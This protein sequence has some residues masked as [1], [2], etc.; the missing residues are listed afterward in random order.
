MNDTSTFKGGYIEHKKKNLGKIILLI[1]LLIIAVVVGLMVGFSYL[2]TD[3]LAVYEKAINET[4]ELLNEAIDKVENNTFQL[5]YLNDPFVFN[6]DFKIVSNLEELSSLTDVNFD[7][8][9]GLDVA[10]ELMNFEL[11][12]TANNNHVI[13]ALFYYANNNMYFQSMDLYEQVIDYGSQDWEEIFSTNSFTV[14]SIELADIRQ[15]I[16]EMKDII[17]GSLAE[18]KFSVYNE[19][20]TVNGEIVEVEAVAYTLDAENQIRTSEYIKEAILANEELMTSLSNIAGLTITELETVLKTEDEETDLEDMTFIL[21]K[22]GNTIMAGSLLQADEEIMNFTYQDET[23]KLTLTDEDNQLVLTVSDASLAIDV[24]LEEAYNFSV[25]YA[26]NDFELVMTDSA[27]T[28]SLSLTN[29]DTS[30]RRLAADLVLN[31]SQNEDGVEEN[32][33]IEG[34]ISLEKR[35]ISTIDTEN[36]VSIDDLSDEDYAVIYENFMQ[37]LERLN[38]TDVLM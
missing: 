9:L 1:V 22:K 15:V 2:K 20:I 18:D 32:I 27:I 37:V 36:A 3:P 13:N 11:E 26:E 17:I 34:S 24:S 6:A 38:L 35:S 28:L 25:T 23:L 19:S 14:P 8:S 30:S 10:Q 33:G 31:I 7:V 21:Y 5:D 12:L 29:I 4:Y 16:T